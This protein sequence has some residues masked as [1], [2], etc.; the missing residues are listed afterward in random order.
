VLALGVARVD[1]EAA[2]GVGRRVRHRG[3]QREALRQRRQVAA[4]GADALEAVTPR[5]GGAA[6]AEGGLEGGGHIGKQ[7]FSS[8]GHTTGRRMREA[9]WSISSPRALEDAALDKNLDQERGGGR[10]GGE[11][12]PV[13]QALLK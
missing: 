10:A 2:R 3:R 8:T 9:S 11:M 5:R 6:G 1:V 12:Y 13:T 7:S 4:A